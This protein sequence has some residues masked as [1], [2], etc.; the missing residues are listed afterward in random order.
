MHPTSS[1]LRRPLAL[2]LFGTVAGLSTPAWAH[3]DALD[4]PVVGAART[5]LEKGDVAPLVKWVKP[6]LE[7]E[8]RRAF[9]LAR[10]VRRRGAVARKLADRYFFETLVR[11]HR[12]SEGFPFTGLKP[13]GRPAHPAVEAT[14]RAL[15]A[16]S[17][18]ALS[19]RLQAAVAAG[20]R[21][22]WQRALETRRRAERSPESGRK[23]VAAYVDL[24][25]YVKRL[26]DAA[27]SGGHGHGSR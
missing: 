1:P 22:R 14:E 20:L 25:H 10:A 13:A 16:G 17:A 23:W 2:L 6:A 26:H 9:A 3:C 7:G 4:G 21:A 18:A 11:L 27:A 19:E 5:A 8:V 12:A 24:I 15:E